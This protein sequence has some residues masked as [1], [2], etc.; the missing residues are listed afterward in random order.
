[1]AGPAQAAS[2]HPLAQNTHFLDRLQINCEP[3]NLLGVYFARI[4]EAA[5]DLDIGLA[6]EPVSKLVD[7][8]SQNRES[9]RQLIP[10]FDPAINKLDETNSFCL[11]AY[12][13]TGEPVASGTC[14][15]YDW[16]ATTYRDELQTLRMFYG[17]PATHAAAAERCDVT[18]ERAKQVSGLVVYAGA[19][20][21]HPKVRGKSL[22][23]LIPR[24][25]KALALANWN[26]DHMVGLM[27]ED[28]VTRGL[29]ARFGYTSPE[30]GALIVDRAGIE[31]NFAVLSMLRDEVITHVRTYLTGDP[32]EID[33]I[34]DRRLA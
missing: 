5:T 21:C 7:I 10:A 26:F 31:R 11:I 30:T 4:A 20:W 15:L 32:P 23:S 19:A 16:T 3:V 22:S 2:N 17:D 25:S 12:D 14:R 1:M 24:T 8:N 28:S 18:A 33:A 13:S 34:I 29:A 9:W 27:L 6:L